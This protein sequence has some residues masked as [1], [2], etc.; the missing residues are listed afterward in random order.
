MKQFLRDA[1]DNIASGFVSAWTAMNDG[2]RKFCIGFGLGV[3]CGA[4]F[5]GLLL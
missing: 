1:W 2:A 4:S 5:V 3:L